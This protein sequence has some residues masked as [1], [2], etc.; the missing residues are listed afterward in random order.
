[1]TVQPKTPGLA[2][3]WENLHGKIYALIL[4][5][6]SGLFL[7]K[8]HSR[9]LTTGMRAFT[10]KVD[11]ELSTFDWTLPAEDMNPDAAERRSAIERITY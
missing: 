11:A 1:M 10:A 8:F 6:P 7:R 3:E 9:P 5:K 2:I 4:H